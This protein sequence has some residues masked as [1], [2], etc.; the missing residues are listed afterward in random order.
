[1]VLELSQSFCN[2]AR[3]PK[4]STTKQTPGMEIVGIGVK[5]RIQKPR[6]PSK[7]PRLML[8]NIARVK[9]DSCH[10]QTIPFYIKCLPAF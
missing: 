2:L 10:W 3:F 5:M 6:C 4:S 9:L 1:M 7:T 8:C